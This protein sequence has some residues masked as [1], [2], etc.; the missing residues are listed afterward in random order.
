MDGL[1]WLLKWMIWGYHYF[2]KHPF[3]SMYF[4]FKMGIFQPAMFVYRR[5]RDQY[6]PNLSPQRAMFFFSPEQGRCK[7]V[8]L[9]DFFR[10]NDGWNNFLM[11][12]YFLEGVA[13]VGGIPL[14][15]S[16]RLGETC[17]KLQNNYCS[18]L[19]LGLDFGLGL[20]ALFLG[21][22]P[23]SFVTGVSCHDSICAIEGGSFSLHLCHNQ[24]GQNHFQLS[25]MALTQSEAMVWDS[26]SH[27]SF[28]KFS[29]STGKVQPWTWMAESQSSFRQW[30]N[31]KN[32]K[33]VP[34]QPKQTD[35]FSLLTK[36]CYSSC[37][38]L[39][40]NM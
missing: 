21:F 2:W 28:C 11:K 38:L 29:L 26:F 15:F 22:L 17:T 16:W 1:L 5:V 12:P 27:T 25:R 9:R 10:E 18:Y 36:K 23:S 19:P 30:P 20:R 3:E 32:T 40:K 4:L 24:V 33:K 31:E 35:L 34:L 14:E 39:E 13:L 8:L 6:Q 7:A 37:L